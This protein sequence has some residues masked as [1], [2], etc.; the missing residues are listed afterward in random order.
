MPTRRDAHGN[1]LPPRMHVSRA[2]HYHV[3]DN[4]W[5]PLG[6]VY[7]DAL[8]EWAKLEGAGRNAR[9]VAQAA[10]AFLIERGPELSP[11]TRSGYAGSQKRLAPVF[12]ACDLKEVTRPDVIGISQGLQRTDCRNQSGVRATVQESQDRRA[13][14]PRCATHGGHERRGLRARPRAARPRVHSDHAPSVSGARYRQAG[15][16]R[17]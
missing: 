16:V 10:E 6:K 13:S 1:V 3:A 11:R 4:C 2:A 12:G 14:I 15:E 5:R 9:T 17:K 8:R 7:A